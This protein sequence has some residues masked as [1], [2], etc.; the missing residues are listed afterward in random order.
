MDGKPRRREELFA[1]IFETFQC[2]GNIS[3]LVLTHIAWKYANP[4]ADNL[5][6]AVKTG[7]STF[8]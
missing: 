5:N 3:T 6:T 1:D 8:G 7:E 4:F 2:M